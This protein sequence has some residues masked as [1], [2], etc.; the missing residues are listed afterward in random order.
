MTKLFVPYAWRCLPRFS[1]VENRN[2]LIN[3]LRNRKDSCHQICLYCKKS[4]ESLTEVGKEEE[5]LLTDLSNKLRSIRLARDPH[6]VFVI[7]PYIKWGPKMKKNTT[8]QLQLEEAEAL[9]STLPQWKVVS[10]LL[11]PLTSFDKTTF[12]SKGHLENI[13]QKTRS[14]Q[15]I[16]SV[17]VNVKSLQLHQHL[18]LE[19]LLKVPVFDRHSIVINI[20]KNHA[21]TREA[22]LQVSLAEIPY[23]WTRIK[24]INEGEVF[25]VSNVGIGSG[26]TFEEKRMQIL[27]ERERKIKA[28]INKL[29]EN[30]QHLR[31]KRKEKEFPTVAVVGYTNA[32]KTSL[33][34]ALTNESDL[35]PENKLF[36][37][38]D[39]TL[40]AVV[41]PTNVKVLLVDTIGFISD[42]PSNLLEPFVVTLE[43]AI[44]AD[45]IIH[46]Q[47]LSHPDRKA[48]EQTVLSTLRSL[49]LPQS[50]LD[51]II[52][53][54]NKVDKIKDERELPEDILQVS[55]ID[56]R[57]L[58]DLMNILEKQVYKNTNLKK[59]KIKVSNGG[60]E[61]RWLHKE[62]AVF[63]VEEDQN[64]QFLILGVA[65]SQAK[66]E[67]FKYEFIVKASK[68]K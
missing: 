25:Q 34:K 5:E 26:Q 56:G 52:T 41:L 6:Q 27:R 43:D 22:K 8:P 24:G 66:L 46:V 15:T 32:G 30:R 4:E 17:F 23:F 59:I 54:G 12:F 63:S 28:E 29:R 13:V 9:V 62:A 51:S 21:K 3:L 58:K 55:C 53:V 48:Q 39:V 1:F 40:H 11:V 57:G 33:I 2:V 65:I 37:T 60:D 38:L 64:P 49:E 42:I 47:D 50:L 14:E 68:I 45:V 36:A 7:Q 18:L 19:D 16:S 10:S 35:K 67:K 61:Y 44:W 20:F 31:S